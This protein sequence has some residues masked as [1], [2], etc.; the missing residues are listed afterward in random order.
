MELQKR[1]EGER[2]TLGTGRI[3]QTRRRVAD[4]KRV[5]D[6]RKGGLQKFLRRT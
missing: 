3:T 6:I 5:A 4:P 1:A 2:G